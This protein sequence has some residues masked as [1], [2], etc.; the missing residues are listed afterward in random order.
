MSMNTSDK[1]L[2]ALGQVNAAPSAHDGDCHWL[3]YSLEV[4]SYSN[5]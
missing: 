2:W 4:Y 5:R 1:Q 3:P